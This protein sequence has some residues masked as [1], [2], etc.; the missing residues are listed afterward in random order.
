MNAVAVRSFLKMYALDPPAGQEED[1][2]IPH[3]VDQ[4]CLQAHCTLNGGL[5]TLLIVSAYDMK[6]AVRNIDLMREAE[7]KSESVSSHWAWIDSDTQAEF[8]SKMFGITPSDYPQVVVWHPRKGRFATFIGSFG[9]TAV[10]TFVTKVVKGKEATSAVLIGE[11]AEPLSLQSPESPEGEGKGTGESKGQCADLVKEI[12]T[13]IKK[14][15][16]TKVT[17]DADDENREKHPFEQFGGVFAPQPMLKRGG[18]KRARIYPLKEET[19]DLHVTA[20]EGQ[21]WI[22]RFHHTKDSEAAAAHAAE[23]GVEFNEKE[24]KRAAYSLKNMVNFATLDMDEYPVVG[25][26]H[27]ISSAGIYVFKAGSDKFTDS[28]E[29]DGEL[30]GEALSEFAY[31]LLD[32][33]F[34]KSGQTVHSIV[35]GGISLNQVIGNTPIQPKIILY[36]TPEKAEKEAPS[37]MKT[38]ALE[39]PGYIQCAVMSS[40]LLEDARGILGERFEKADPPV[41]SIFYIQGRPQ[42]DPA[43]P[44]QVQVSMGSMVVSGKELNFNSMARQFDQMRITWPVQTQGEP[45]HDEL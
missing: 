24:W 37:L 23:T 22:V 31:A 34:K 12:T 4:S 40:E 45:I 11:D 36:T 21:N 29:Y 43:V 30:T 26:S 6:R 5:C 15:K 44:G 2:A 33:S 17:P 25:K 38:L 27:G 19:F 18:K 16:K 10:A 14:K 7:E 1:F 41:P 35:P 3:A 9:P 39:F 13:G 8:V 32:E 42:E 28:E 20:R